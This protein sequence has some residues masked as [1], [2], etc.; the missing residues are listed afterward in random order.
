VGD[1]IGAETPFGGRTQVYVSG[2]GKKLG[3]KFFSLSSVTMRMGTLSAVSQKASRARDGGVHTVIGVRTLPG[4]SE[5]NILP[6][7]G[8][9]SRGGGRLSRLGRRRGDEEEAAGGQRGIMRTRDVMVTFEDVSGEAIDVES[10]RSSEV[11]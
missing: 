6:A 10:G 5:E 2:G 4:E 7:G 8:N 1:D 11:F 9:G 3:S